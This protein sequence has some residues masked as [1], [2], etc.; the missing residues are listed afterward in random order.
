MARLPL[1]LAALAAAAPAGAATLRPLT[2]LA[3]PVVRL[4][5]L[6]DDAG[7]R[8]DRVLGPGPAPGARIVVEAAQLAAIAR[9]FGV[10]WRPASAAD[11]AVLDRPGRL[12]PRDSITVP[13]LAALTRV[14]APAD[15]E[16]D[17]PG[18]E[19]PLVPAEA[20][21][22]VTVEQVDY[23][24]ATGRFAAAVLIG[25]PAMEPLRLRLAGVVE[26]LAHVLVP[27]RRL[28][29]GSVLRA[30]DLLPATVRASVLRGDVARE[31]AQALGLALRHAAAAGQPLPLAELQPPVLV[32][33]GAHV[34][35]EI[36]L[37]GLAVVA[38]G[39]ALEAGALG[40]RIAVLNPT[41]RMQVEGTIVGP[42]RVTV[43]TGSVPLPERGAAP[44]ADQ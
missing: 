11:R 16:L 41:S 39:S 34:A 12:L 26:A 35:M 21:P 14:G 1:I 18:F 8:A 44:A 23:E 9:Q 33:K 7:P 10:D 3:A 40:D 2:T 38:Q 30:A 5:D 29:A 19:T 24:G 20:A 17:L 15:A 6:F 13:L 22:T 27:A 28:A 31:P 42:D 43:A 4:S 32:A 25:G 37:P 36:R